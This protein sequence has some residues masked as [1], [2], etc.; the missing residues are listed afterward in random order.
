MRSLLHAPRT[1]KRSIAAATLGA[2]ALIGSL[3]VATPAHALNDTG[4]GGVFVPSSGRILD[5]AKGTGGFSTPMEAG[6][7]RT[8]KVAG[9]AGL[10]VDGSVGAVS[11]NAT[12]GGS[13]GYGTLFGRPDTDTGRTTMLIYNGVSG[14]YT[15]N[16]ATLAVGA[17][18]TIQVMT[19]TSARL[20]LDVQGYY[21]ANT[22]GTA[23]GGFVPVTKR[24]VVTRSGIGA[25]KAAIGPG[26][27]IDVQVT[28]ANGIP[29]GASGAVV[30]LI[31]INTNAS[32]GY[33]TP[34]ATGATKP[35]NSLHYAP[36][37]NT[38]I[39]AQ[40]PLSAD[41]KMTIANSVTTVDLIVDV[42][43]YFTA[44]GKG[45][46]VFTPA[47]GRAY[48][49]RATG[50]TALGEQETRSIQIAGTAGVPAMGSGITAVVLTL[51]VAHGGGDGY[52]DVYADGKTNPGITAINFNTGE[53]QT[54]TITVPLGANGKIALRNAA[55]A[56]NYV[57]DVQGWYTN[58]QTPKISCPAA[59]AAG[60][61]TAA[62]PDSA[63]S[64]TITG[65][66]AAET[67]DA[68]LITLDGE[69]LD[70][71]GL[72]ATAT[73]MTDVEVAAVQGAHTLKARLISGS[74][75]DAAPSA[76][77]QFGLGDWATKQIVPSI[78]DGDTVPMSPD[79]A[80]TIS[81]ND[82][83][84]EDGLITYRVYKADSTDPQI[85]SDAL[86]ADTPFSLSQGVL[87]ANTQYTWN[88]TLVGRSGAS[89]TTK[90]LTSPSWAF[91]TNDTDNVEDA[92]DACAAKLATMTEDD[93][94][95]SEAASSEQLGYACYGDT[96]EIA[97]EGDGAPTT[98]A[99]TKSRATAVASSNPSLHYVYNGTTNRMVSVAGL[100]EDE[101]ESA[102]ASIQPDDSTT[103]APASS[104]VSRKAGKPGLSEVHEKINSEYREVLGVT[105]TYGE[106]DSQGRPIT[107]YV[108]KN[109]VTFS[110]GK[111]T[112][113]DYSY[114]WTSL[115]NRLTSPS[116]EIRSYQR[117]I[118]P[119]RIDTVFSGQGKG[120]EMVYRTS[121]TQKGTIL[122]NKGRYQYNFDLRQITIND[123][124]K[125]QW[126]AGSDWF[127]MVTGKRFQCYKTV[128]C[129][130]PNGKEAP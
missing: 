76:T 87:Q 39:Q 115:S 59:Y 35:V 7:Y 52:A 82:E 8:I 91:I 114:S 119:I 117:A 102:V 99:T 60:S 86:P 3:L 103:P 88:A 110:L 129:K 128:G 48:D 112:T 98:S 121:Y 40:V 77:Y 23:A 66:L 15:S 70:P 126:H 64:C 42:Q 2:L 71:V 130:F 62:I 127:A 38:S 50:N 32:D 83:L 123:M 113:A 13:S 30:N 94:Y 53:I 4:T 63:I 122:L 27:S 19:E 100:T 21:T 24:I 9:L 61:W 120:A 81:G 69:E 47:Y 85:T 111:L 90:T 101:A 93:E 97:S 29:A 18:G 57:V 31:A 55:K 5:T 43:G 72:S 33:L 37:E 108:L 54:N 28:G 12:V 105:V 65:P 74:R 116:L 22:D 75:G 106:Q 68:V 44:A 25:A 125:G 56:T 17:D 78:A 16:T 11:L 89:Q 58:P 1:R 34:Y 41:G 51:I 67:D 79:L 84:P 6:K 26:K 73:T 109:T 36:S 118:P 10:P 46:A 14:E 80:V 107:A 20:I 45:G 92:K 104:R 49:S 124:R 96:A 95:D